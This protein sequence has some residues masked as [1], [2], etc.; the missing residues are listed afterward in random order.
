M[1]VR[2]IQSACCLAVVLSAAAWS[3]DPRPRVSAERLRDDV[4]TLTSKPWAGRGAGTEGLEQAGNWLAEQFQ[5]IG[6]RPVGD[7]GTYKQKF[8]ITVSASAGTSNTLSCTGCGTDRLEAGKDFNPLPMTTNAT[9]EAELVFAGYGITAPECAYDDY[10]DIDARGRIVLILRHEPGEYDAKSVFDG[11]VYTEHSQ[12]MKKILTAREHGAVA[13][14]MVNDT[15]SHSGADTLDAFT[16]LPGPGQA[17]LPVMQIRPGTVE[18]WFK[19]A[20]RDFGTIQADID[21][22]V[23]PRSFTFTGMKFALRTDVQSTQAPVFNVAGYMPGTTDEYVVIGAHYDHLGLGEQYSLAQD[24]AG[25]AHPGADDNA[26]GTAGVLELARWFASQPPMRRGVLFLAFSGE[27][28]GLL[29]STHYTSSP[30]LPMERAV[31]MLNMDMIGRLRDRKLTVGGVSS[32]AGLRE[33]LEEI[34][35]RHS[36]NLQMGED[37]VYGSSDH[38]AFK[39]RLVPVLFFFTGLHADYHRP[40]DTP[41][42]IDAKATA[43]VVEFAGAAATGLAQRPERLAFVRAGE[44]NSLSVSGMGR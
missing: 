5:R 19:R 17:G 4:R 43:R 37:A 6:L 18:E 16:S 12:T 10:R 7:S 25:T 3:R 34:G 8:R 13:V 29:G 33:M 23:Q 32:G 21:S 30:L 42:K 1:R 22:D 38:T 35:K 9:V 20:G 11:R 28:I 15:A 44:N 31:A 39:A 40:G 36:L 24:Q 27:E 41:D 14:L 26:S 2:S